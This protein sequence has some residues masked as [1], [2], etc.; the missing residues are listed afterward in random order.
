MKHIFIGAVLLL[1]LVVSVSA[2][3][4]QTWCGIQTLYF[5]HNLSTSPAGYEELI[6]Y[7][8]GNTEV[9]E[10]V[11]VKSSDGLVLIDNYIMPENSLTHTSELLKGLRRYRVYA[12]VSGASG[13]TTLNFTAFKRFINGTEVNFYS[14]QTEDINAL[15]VTEYDL[16]Y[17]SQVDL[18]LAPTDRLGIRVYGQ[19]THSATVT[20]NWV[21]QGN[22]HTSHFE[23]GYFVCPSL[24][25]GGTYI[26]KKTPVSDYIPLLGL[27]VVIPFIVR[28][29]K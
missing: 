11:A 24:P 10:S 29:R 15:T 22:T 23:S 27:L 21:Y 8:S 28:K 13:T 3:P 4:G 25:T 16:N 2:Q 20:L 12:Y 14:A 5:Q 7:P 17:V 1:L 18:P 6:N 26:I 9:D 19:T